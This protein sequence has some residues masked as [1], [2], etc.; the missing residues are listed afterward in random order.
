MRPKA[1]RNNANAKSSFPDVERLMEETAFGAERQLHNV[2]LKAFH[3][4]PYLFIGLGFIGGVM[5]VFGL[6]HLLEELTS[7]HP[8]LIL[9]LG[10]FI[11]T[12]TGALHKRLSH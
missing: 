2:R 1:V 6:E 9:F 8:L 3:R 10:L 12:A 4:F 7:A 11:L 5:T